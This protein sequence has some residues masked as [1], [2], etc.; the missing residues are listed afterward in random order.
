[1]KDNKTRGP[2][3]W[4][5]GAGKKGVRQCPRLAGQTG[6]TYKH[7]DKPFHQRQDTPGESINMP[8][9]PLPPFTKG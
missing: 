4:K 7:V 8:S 3:N 1:M 5:T 2:G 6:H 9:L